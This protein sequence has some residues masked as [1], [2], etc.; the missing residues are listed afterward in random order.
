MKNKDVKM[1]ISEDIIAHRK[2]T[3]NVRTKASMPP[4]LDVFDELAIEF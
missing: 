4:P 1:Q 2:L 3:A